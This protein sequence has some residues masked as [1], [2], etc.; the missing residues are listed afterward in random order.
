MEGKNCMLKVAEQRLVCFSHLIHL[1]D[2]TLEWL[3]PIAMVGG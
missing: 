1:L 3:E 2:L